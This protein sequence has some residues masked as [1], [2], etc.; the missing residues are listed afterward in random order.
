MSSADILYLVRAALD[1]FDSV[2]LDVSIRRVV[3]IA[4]LLGETKTALRMSMEVMAVGGSQLAN[5]ED[6]RRLISNSLDDDG[7]PSVVEEA[8]LTE[9]FADRALDDGKVLAGSVGMLS[10]WLAAEFPEPL[11]AL[12]KVEALGAKLKRIEILD[13]T[14]SRA[15]SALCGWERQLEFAAANESLLLV[16]Q[17]RVDALLAQV[18]PE[19]LDQFNAVFRRLNEAAA[20][21]RDAEAKE[22][23]AQAVTSCRR[24]LKAVVDLVQPVDSLTPRSE[25]GHALTDEAYKNRLREFL[26]SNTDSESYSGALTSASNSLFERFASIDKLAS[27]G[28]HASV[29]RQEAEF[30]A[31]NTYTLAGEILRKLVQPSATG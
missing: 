23:L 8:A 31:L 4:N 20:R 24:I 18:A 1:E 13:R 11:S 28:V 12:Q 7:Q 26:K 14:R 5:R 19:V 22:E 16:H 9:F 6:L 17:G 30:C 15:F 2:D 29:A 3:R 25:D 10:V 27:K 21:D